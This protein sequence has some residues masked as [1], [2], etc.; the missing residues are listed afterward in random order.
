MNSKYLALIL[1]QIFLRNKFFCEANLMGYSWS[2]VCFY[3]Y[4]Q[5]T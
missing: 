5:L 1:I 4:F 3:F 2:F